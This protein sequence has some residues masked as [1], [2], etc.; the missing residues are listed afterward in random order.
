ME[1]S[2]KEYY[3]E[4]HGKTP[5]KKPGT[6]D[7]ATKDAR[8][9]KDAIDAFVK[10]INILIVKMFRDE[11]DKGTRTDLIVTLVIGGLAFTVA[12]VF[13]MLAKELKVTMTP[14]HFT[15]NFM[16]MFQTAMRDIG[17]SEKEES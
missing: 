7:N 6:T 11:Q 9:I 14:E 1:D 17:K 4:T 10:A 12:N 3:L 2:F 13:Y 16:G 8:T 15:M 5:D